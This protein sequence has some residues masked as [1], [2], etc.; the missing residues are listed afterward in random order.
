MDEGKISSVFYTIVVPM[1][2][3]IIYNLRNKDVKVALRKSLI[4]RKF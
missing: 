4:R 3:P 1:M 2:S